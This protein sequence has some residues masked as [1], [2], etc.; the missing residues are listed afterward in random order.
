MVLIRTIITKIVIMKTSIFYLLALLT[1]IRLDAQTWDPLGPDDAYP[2]S[3]GGTEYSNIAFDAS[4]TAYVALKDFGYSAKM[5]VKKLVNGNWITVGTEGFSN[6]VGFACMALDP[7]GVPYIAYKDNGTSLK[8]TVMKF[9]GTSWV[10][11]GPAGISVGS[12]DDID[13]AINAAGEPYVAY[14]DGGNSNRTV[15]K[16]FNGTSWVLVGPAQ[17]Q[18]GA[19][20]TASIALDNTGVP[21]VA[22]TDNSTSNKAT[23]KKF[24]G[25]TWATVGSAGIS[26]GGAN[27]PEIAID[28]SNN[29]YVAFQDAGASF[30]AKVM[31]FNGTSWA[32]VGSSTGI[33]STSAYEV[34]IALSS[35]GTPYIAYA[36]QGVNS[37]ATVLKYNGSAWATVG[38]TGF[39]QGGASWLSIAIS[40]SGD[41]MVV[42]NDNITYNSGDKASAM[43]FNGTSWVGVSAAGFSPTDAAFSS[44]AIDATGAP[45]VI[46]MDRT[47]SS[48]TTVKRFDGTSWNYLG[49]PGFSAGGAQFMKM[50]ADPSGTLHVVYIDYGNAGKATVMKYNGTSWVNVG[51]AGFSAGQV[52]SPSIAFDAAGTP[53][54]CYQ[55]APNSGKVTVKKFNGTSWVNVGNAAFTSA[56]ATYPMMAISPTGEPHVVFQDNANQFKPSVMKFDGA[57]WTFVG[58]PGISQYST[59]NVDIAFDPS[60]TPYIFFLNGF[61]GF[62]MKFDGSAWASVGSGVAIP[63]PTNKGF[64]FDASGTPYIAYTDYNNLGKAGV[65]KFNGT[66]WVQVGPAAITSAQMNYTSMVLSGSYLYLAGVVRTKAVAKRF[67]IPVAPSVT[68]SASSGTTACAGSN[69]SFTATASAAGSTPSYQWRVNGNAAGSNGSSFI[70]NALSTGDLID[71]I[72]TSSNAGS[73]TDTSNAFTVSINPLPTASISPSSTQ[74]IC[75]GQTKLFQASTD[76]GTAYQWYLSGNPI[77]GAAASSYNAAA[78]GD[79]TVAITS[80][81]GCVAI[82]TAVTLTVNPLPTVSINPSVSQTICD[83]GQVS[84]QAT[85]ASGLSYQWRDS[86]NPL[87]G[88]VSSSFNAMA[89]GSYSLLA[90]DNNGCSATTAAVAVTVNSLP[91]ASFTTDTVNNA[92]HLSVSGDTNHARQ[93]LLNGNPIPGATNAAY[94][95]MSSG[96]YSLTVTNAAGCS[97][98]SASVSVTTCTSAT[99]GTSSAP[100]TVCAGLAFTLSNSGSSAGFGMA[101]QW[102]VDNGSGWTNIPGATTTDYTLPSGQ[103]APAMYRMTLSCIHSGL[104]DISNIMSVGISAFSACYCTPVNNNDCSSGFHITSVHAMGIGNNSGTCTSGDSYSDYTAI[105]PA[106]AS[107]GGRYLVNVHV[108]DSGPAHASAWIDFNHSGAF[109]STEFIDLNSGSDIG[110]EWV[111][112]NT[113]NIPADAL[114]GLTRMR[115]RSRNNS[116]LAAT[117]SCNA[118]SYGETEDYMINIVTPS[119]IQPDSLWITDVKGASLKVNYRRGSG[120]SYKGMIIVAKEGSDFSSDPVNNNSYTTVAAPA[121][122]VL[123]IDPSLGEIAPGAKVIYRSNITTGT[124]NNK[125]FTLSGLSMDKDY[126]FRAYAYDSSASGVVYQALPVRFAQAHTLV[127]GPKKAPSDPVITNLTPYSFDL[128]WSPGDGQRHMVIMHKKSPVVSDLVDGSSYPANSAYGLGADVSDLS[129]SM[130]YVVYSGADSTAHITNLETNTKYNIVVAPYNGGINNAGTEVYSGKVLKT[131]VT[132]VKDYIE[133]DGTGVPV[134]E[135]FDFLSTGTNAQGWYSNGSITQSDGS[136]AANGIYCFGSSSDRSYGSLGSGNSFGARFINKSTDTVTSILVQYTG[137]QWRNGGSGIADILNVEYSTD[138]YR[139][140]DASQYMSVVPASWTPASNLALSSPVSGAAAGALNGNLPANQARISRSIVGLQLAPGAGVWIRFSDNGVSDDGLSIDDLTMVSFSNTLVGNSSITTKNFSNLNLVGGT[141][142][143]DTNM[144]TVKKAF[145]IEEGT[146]IDISNADLK[147]TLNINSYLFGKG[148]IS[149]GPLSAVGIDGD[150]LGQHLLFTPSSNTLGSLNIKADASATLDNAVYMS[151][152]PKAGIVK[153]GSDKGNAVLN[154][155]NNLTLGSDTLGSAII[156]EVYGSVNGNVTIE[157]A[158]S[159]R[160]AK[161]LLSHP[162]SAAIPLSQ[163]ADDHTLDFISPNIWHYNYSNTAGPIEDVALDNS[164]TPFTAATDQWNVNDIIRLNGAA[165][166]QLDING[167]VNQGP[168]TVNINS[169]ASTWIVGGNPYPAGVKIGQALTDPANGP[170][171]G[172]GNMSNAAIYIWDPTLAVDGAF[173]VMPGQGASK[174]STKLEKTTLPIG[175]AYVAMMNNVSS[176]ATIEFDETLKTNTGNSKA[177]F[178]EGSAEEQEMETVNLSETLPV[179]LQLTAERNGSF[180]DGLYVFFDQDAAAKYEH[181][182]APKL[183][184]PGFNFYTTAPGGEKL[185]VDVRPFESG[186]LIPMGLAAAQNGDYTFRAS[187]YNLPAGTELYLV[188]KFLG[189]QQLLSS[190]TSYGF[191]VSADPA[192]QGSGRFA[193]KMG[194]STFPGVSLQVELVPNPASEQVTIRVH[195]PQDGKATVRIL[196]ATGQLMSVSE[197]ASTQHGQ[198]TIPLSN[199]AA[200][201]YM[202]E[203]TINGTKTIK[204]LVKQ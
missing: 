153:I 148:T 199:L 20:F 151:A 81:A 16:K 84:F 122:S 80:P 4:G 60:G 29:V 182:D 141:H 10:N 2:L 172:T 114:T 96:D 198:L 18:N 61:N 136:S 147:R 143:V 56:D 98:T 47:N 119:S 195:N 78:Q 40:P 45:C 170:A 73:L 102:Q 109:E 82:A 117:S 110:A 139:F 68:I 74:Q 197:M 142:T 118:Y 50:A 51:A 41:P 3:T 67:E 152:V 28:A 72:V 9:N 13:M 169:G 112:E 200:G 53:F 184:N 93:W 181:S 178:K 24:N 38:S 35:T 33:S 173:K 125:T 164:W 99:A 204:Q 90:T 36:D 23:V 75:A 77:G 138:A 156:D 158:F 101:Y 14:M 25:T 52:Y 149:S 196:S 6:V 88:A 126:Y 186:K 104:S 131:T 49:T 128:K 1:C 175:G 123:F 120:V 55:D 145:N 121:A 180:Y 103:S 71:C 150:D 115:I 127:D 26:T 5:V 185:S 140:D 54:V 113:V 15:V 194:R 94:V 63:G 163:L 86:G 188:D 106:S 165:F 34:A 146:T 157:R 191:T 201:T 7:N 57:D 155:N 161:R 129:S 12:A 37:K 137:E 97:H 160:N 177:F 183:S 133:L 43:A 168:L 162:F 64:V 76:I 91:V 59:D 130:N 83:G 27:Y 132:T 92:L 89:S 167:A 179:G 66:S 22:F 111:F 85:P 65:R 105:D 48:K 62:V 31:K 116:T 124:N 30:K 69:L 171:N 42:Y 11:V 193:L 21:Y 58:T 46:Y 44:I 79:Y 32:A 19:A 135:S 187:D 17:I 39:T 203:L 100:T 192:S 190:G 144:V 174:A 189:T 8:L 154:T 134:T 202:V 176:T 159:S 107:T 70:T 87:S 95:P 108:A 166:A